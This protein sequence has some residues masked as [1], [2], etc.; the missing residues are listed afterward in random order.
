MQ[1]VTSDKAIA[2]FVARFAST[3]PLEIAQTIPRFPSTERPARHSPI[4]A[5]THARVLEAQ[6][7]SAILPVAQ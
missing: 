4:A 2:Q 7:H 6:E 3:I 1:R 5:G